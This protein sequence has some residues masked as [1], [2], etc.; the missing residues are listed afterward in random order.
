MV[1]CVVSFG[2]VSVLAVAISDF[3]AGADK[4][5]KLG[6]IDPHRQLVFKVKGLT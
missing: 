5:D 6:K 2:L 4:T 3:G 1:R